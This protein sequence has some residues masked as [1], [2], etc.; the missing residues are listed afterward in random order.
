MLGIIFFRGQIFWP[1]IRIRCLMASIVQVFIRRISMHVATIPLTVSSVIVN[2]LS[3]PR[4]PLVF[5]E[6]R[7]KSRFPSRCISRSSAGLAPVLLIRQTAAKAGRK[8]AS[9]RCLAR[10]TRS[11]SAN[12]LA[13]FGFAFLISVL[14]RS[15]TGFTTALIFVAALICP[16]FSRSKAMAFFNLLKYAG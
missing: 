2:S 4:V 9:P 11:S 15:V 12:D 13:L 10:A 16:L 8:S 1:S 14:P 3:A 6:P 7:M 5:F